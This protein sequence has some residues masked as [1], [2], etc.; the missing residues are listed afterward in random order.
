MTLQDKTMAILSGQVGDE[1]KTLQQFGWK[2]ACLGG[3]IQTTRTEG[4]DLSQRV[5]KV[6]G[7][8]DQ[9]RQEMEEGVALRCGNLEVE[10][11]RQQIHMLRG[12]VQRQGHVLMALKRQPSGGQMP[13]DKQG[14]GPCRPSVV[15]TPMG[16]QEGVG[17]T[18]GPTGSGQRTLS[19]SMAMKTEPG[20]RNEGKDHCQEGLLQG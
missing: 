1:G 5:G 9:M 11:L 18:P 14:R 2:Q 13:Q 3:A 7:V 20:T 16:K 19:T 12:V 17:A 8:V 10:G 15:Q 4:G 6:Q